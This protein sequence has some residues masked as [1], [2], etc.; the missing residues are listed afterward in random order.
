MR[1]LAR[2]FPEQQR[3]P[4]SARVAIQ[5][6]PFMISN[7]SNHLVLPIQRPLHM[8][9]KARAHKHVH[10]AT[11]R[12]FKVRG[13]TARFGAAPPQWRPPNISTESRSISHRQNTTKHV[14]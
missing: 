13:V 11:G 5:L 1:C 6:R 8:F 14:T 7:D 4:E 3:P 9:R 12:I 2:T 10:C